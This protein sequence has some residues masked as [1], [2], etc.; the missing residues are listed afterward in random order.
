MIKRLKWT[1][2]FDGYLW[3]LCDVIA[4][5]GLQEA[6]S[7][8]SGA[9]QVISRTGIFASAKG[10]GR[11][12]KTENLFVAGTLASKPTVRYSKHACRTR[13]IYSSSV[14][15]GHRWTGK[16]LWFKNAFWQCRRKYSWTHLTAHFLAAFPFRSPIH[17]QNEGPF[18]IPIKY[19]MEYWSVCQVTLLQ[20]LL[21]Q[22]YYIL[23]EILH[24][25]Y[26]IDF[27]QGSWSKS[28]G[29]GTHSK[30]SSK[31]HG[32]WYSVLPLQHHLPQPIL[33]R[34]SLQC[35]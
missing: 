5:S 1:V 29:H 23:H 26:N 32:P 16:Y 7:S 17:M 27:V 18:S 20:I 2:I 35:K 9:V 11:C 8:P 28:R 6:H 24:T 10:Q 13:V 14:S 25:F 33:T 31:T 30:L 15:K 22:G 4:G 3:L 12:L 21:E 34:W 19:I